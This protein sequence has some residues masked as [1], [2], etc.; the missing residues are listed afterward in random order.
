M[1]DPQNPTATS[2]LLPPIKS[3]FE[4]FKEWLKENNQ[5]IYTT[6][7]VLFGLFLGLLGVGLYS[8][9]AQFHFGIIVLWGFAYF[10]V[11]ALIGCIFGVPKSVSEPAKTAT[12]A[13]PPP[14][15]QPGPAILPNVSPSSESSAATTSQPSPAATPPSSA[16]KATTNLTDISE[17]LTKI[18]IGAGLVQLKEIPAFIMKVANKM[19]LGI[20]IDPSF[21]SN[22][23]CAGIIVYYVCFGLIS[24]YFVMRTVF[25]KL[26]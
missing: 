9:L 23:L 16:Q 1:D 13:S 10:L 15:S 24:G 6:I 22:I 2:Q 5:Y 12:N 3:E 4:K 26:L 11:G 19:E 17:W 25:L 8:N 18:V 14:A 20:N 21:H 7:W